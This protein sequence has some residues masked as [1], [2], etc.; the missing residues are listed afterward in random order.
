MM[1]NTEEF[2]GETQQAVNYF[3]EVVNMSELPPNTLPSSEISK[4]IC[5]I[6]SFTLKTSFW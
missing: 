1:E 2:S 6:T 5:F 4:Y 3:Q